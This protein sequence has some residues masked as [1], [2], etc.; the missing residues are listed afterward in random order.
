MAGG[1]LLA[2][3]L[4]GIIAPDG[5]VDVG[6]R[7]AH[8]HRL[9]L[10]SAVIYVG[11]G[12]GAGETGHYQVNGPD[13]TPTLAWQYRVIRLWQM[14]AA[15]LLAVERPALLALVGQTQIETPE[16][17]LPDVVARVQ[18]VPEAERRGRLL[19]ALIALIPEEEM[20]TMVERLIDREA[21]LL[22]TPFLRRMRAAC[23]PKAA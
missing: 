7:L 17:V 13:G 18:S 16:T 2:L 20:I 22:D 23:A 15:E 3:H 6:A 1:S 14:R 5:S 11:R 21:L 8:T 9:D 19:A 12:A 10:W 4:V